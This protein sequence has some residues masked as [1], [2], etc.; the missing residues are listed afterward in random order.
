MRLAVPRRARRGGKWRRR[1]RVGAARVSRVSDAPF[2][3]KCVVQCSVDWDAG[4]TALHIL[5]C[6]ASHK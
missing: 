4:C 6:T 2:T 1:F 3:V 5:A